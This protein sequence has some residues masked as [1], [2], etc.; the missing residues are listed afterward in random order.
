MI[1]FLR[2]TNSKAYTKFEIFMYVLVMGLT[3]SCGIPAHTNPKQENLY[4]HVRFLTPLL[5]EILRGTAQ[6]SAL[7]NHVVRGTASIPAIRGVRMTCTT[8]MFRFTLDIPY[9]ETLNV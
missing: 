9:K 1:P 6:D 4:S 2:L 5:A 8:T 7:Q 3:R